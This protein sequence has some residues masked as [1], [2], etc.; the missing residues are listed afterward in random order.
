MAVTTSYSG[1][2]RSNARA[3]AFAAK[4]KRQK[5][6]VA[7]GLVLL[8]LIL[9]Y[10]VP[11]T[12]KMMHGTSTSRPT[13]PVSTDATTS[14]GAATTAPSHKPSALWHTLR[15]APAT[16]PFS[17]KVPAQDPTN[18]VVSVPAGV[19]DPFSPTVNGADPGL[20]QSGSAAPA[21]TTAT[22][23][24]LPKTIV[25]GSPGAGRTAKTGWIL[26]LASIPSGQ[27]RGAANAFAK[28]AMSRGVGSVSILN[29]SNAKPLRGGYWVV[30]TGPFPTLAG[31]NQTASRVHSAGYG[32]AYVRQLVVYGKK[33]N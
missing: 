7:V 26:I 25:V 2:R 12:L 30:Y 16:N 8:L 32:S 27:G 29:S 15:H 33:S 14:S 5:V 3:A 18:K 19:G 31:V 13:T 1:N 17:P 22:S 21:S 6:I 20:T 28:K 10:E 4:Q 11:H 24:S 9:A 23:G